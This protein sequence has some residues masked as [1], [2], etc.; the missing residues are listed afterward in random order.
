[1]CLLFI[2]KWTPSSIVRIELSQI[3]QPQAAQHHILFIPRR[4]SAVYI[5][6]VP[7]SPV[8]DPSAF[9]A[10]HVPFL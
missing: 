2:S 9:L 1:M 10:R 3:I 6:E 5:D 4:T 7:M 8:P